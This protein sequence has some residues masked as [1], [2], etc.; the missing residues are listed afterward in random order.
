MNSYSEILTAIGASLGFAS[1]VW[2]IWDVRWG[3][4]RIG[5][6]LIH[7]G[8]GR[9]RARTSVSN[10]RNYDRGIENALLL[11]GPERENPIRTANLLLVGIGECEVG[12]TNDLA[13]RKF[14]GPITGEGGR[15]IIPL[16]FYYSEN[17]KIG[18]EVVTASAPLPLERFEPGA[19][20]S[21]RFFLL[22]VG[23]YHRSTHDCFTA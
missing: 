21:V 6:E 14:D 7:Y 10:T 5:M 13:S 1:F 2:K 18:D 15:M 12:S 19:S 16:P 22:P 20:Y 11:I 8:E 9:L 3:C 23:R 4:L 17:L